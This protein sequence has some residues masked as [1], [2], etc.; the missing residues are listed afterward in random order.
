MWLDILLQEDTKVVIPVN[1]MLTKGDVLARC[2]HKKKR[3]GD[4]DGKKDKIFRLQFHTCELT[5]QQWSIAFDKSGL[6][7]VK[8]FPNNCTVTFNFCKDRS[9]PLKADDTMNWGAGL[10]AAYANTDVDVAHAAA[11]MFDHARVIK[12][13]GEDG[14][15][16]EDVA[17]ATEKPS[18]AAGP[19][20]G[21]KSLSNARAVDMTQMTEEDRQK[22]MDAVKSGKC[23]VDD[24]V[25]YVLNK[26][27]LSDAVTSPD[28]TTNP[29]HFGDNDGSPRPSP[30]ATRKADSTD[31]GKA[32]TK[33][34][35]KKRSA[36][37][38]PPLSATHSR[39][40]SSSSSAAISPAPPGMSPNPFAA[41][42]DASA[43]HGDTTSGATDP[44]EATKQS[45]RRRHSSV[46]IPP[47]DAESTMVGNPFDM[48][49]E[50]T[51]GDGGDAAYN[52]FGEG[53]PQQDKPARP[54]PPTSSALSNLSHRSESTEGMLRPK[55]PATA[56][57][58]A[59]R[60][61][62][63]LVVGVGLGGGGAVDKPRNPFGDADSNPFE[64]SAASA[65]AK[66]APAGTVPGGDSGTATSTSEETPKGGVKG[67]PLKAFWSV[68]KEAATSK[69]PSGAKPKLHAFWDTGTPLATTTENAPPSKS[70]P[71]SPPAPT[72]PENESA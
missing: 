71:T 66:P 45:Q 64:M 19:T 36:G 37:L 25:L 41:T 18:A 47:A 33:G 16:K 32:D 69:E 28:F 8:Q 62:Q 70:A 13:K 57:K 20:A 54:P 23:S 29:F 48:P 4:G 14:N 53:T 49:T 12:V 38:V 59:H 55:A 51:A 7:D 56:A 39:T 24:A 52:P 40:P 72:P 5:E 26:E 50:S 43:L 65:G 31:S 10:A 44:A 27:G 34:S 1:R 30:S 63:S 22:I 58:T 60:R 2:Y 6:D 17:A 68:V 46:E 11:V 15:G 35:T 61:S 42:T 3:G 21:A 9:P 67:A